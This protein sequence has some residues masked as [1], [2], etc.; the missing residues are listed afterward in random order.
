MVRTGLGI[1]VYRDRSRP[2]PLGARTL[3]GD[4]GA[5]LHAESLRRIGVE[6][7]GANDPD[8]VIP[9]SGRLITHSISRTEG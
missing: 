5:P 3:R 2:E 6:L 1:G 7:A 8:A 9:P 4:R